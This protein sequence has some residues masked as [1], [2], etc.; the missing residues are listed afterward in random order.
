M[1]G[2]QLSHVNPK[3]LAQDRKSLAAV[4]ALPVYVSRNPEF[5]LAKLTAA[6]AALAAA[7]THF[8]QTD[9]AWEAARD[10]LAAAKRA[11]HD[12]MV[13]AREQV[14]ARFGQDSAEVQSV[15]L[16]RKSERKRPGPKPGSRRKPRT[17]APAT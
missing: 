4:K 2:G 3:R 9:G 17:A 11:F 5:E 13:G 6:E 7:E 10:A 14:T 15:G 12:A 8:V 16:T 1:A